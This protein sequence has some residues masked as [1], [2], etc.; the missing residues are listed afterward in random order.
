MRMFRRDDAP[1]LGGGEYSCQSDGMVGLGC[2]ARSYTQ[3]LH[4]SFDYAVSPRAVRR[5]IDSFVTTTD[6]SRAEVG[7]PLSADESR[8]RYL[9]QSL[10]HASGLDKSACDDLTE[11]APFLD[12][13]WV[14]DTGSHLRLTSEGL[15][16]SD[17]IGPALF[18]PAVRA[19]MAAYDQ[20]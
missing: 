19:A 20:K 4:Y 15:A 6:F 10:L 8:R 11:L 1:D 5:I 16:H 14:T 3:R 7:I 17:A 9:I 13:G 12:R 18:S 2:G